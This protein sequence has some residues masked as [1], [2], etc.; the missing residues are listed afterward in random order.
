M[1]RLTMGIRSDKCVVRRFRRCANVYEYLHKPDSIAYYKPR[2]YRV[3]Y[4][5]QATNLYSRLLY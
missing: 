3:A 5:S 2:L 1:R 4:C